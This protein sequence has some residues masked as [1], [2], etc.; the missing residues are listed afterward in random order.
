MVRIIELQAAML[1]GETGI[2]QIDPQVLEELRA[3]CRVA[4]VPEPLRAYAYGDHPL[5]VTADQNLAAPL[6]P[7]CWPHLAEVER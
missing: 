2:E 7:R 4:F 3:K 6:W 1:S 5:P